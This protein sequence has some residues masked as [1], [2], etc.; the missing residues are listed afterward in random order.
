MFSRRNWF[1]QIDIDGYAV[2]YEFR[3]NTKSPYFTKCEAQV[4]YVR[5]AREQRPLEV[6]HLR[7]GRLRRS[8][9]Q[10]WFVQSRCWLHWRP[11]RI[12]LARGI[13]NQARSIHMP[14]QP[15]PCVLVFHLSNR[16]WAQITW[17]GV[18]EK[19][20]YQSQYHPNHCKGWYH[21][22]DRTATIQIENYPGTVIE[23]RS[24]LSISNGRW[25]RFRG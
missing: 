2:Q 6:N 4:A 20:R 10:R 13:E 23:R 19:T 25:I 3:I 8:D 24:Y 15:D 12:V 22:E 14:W 21:F 11:I 16:S 5:A 17:F 7:Y 9:Q 18:H 1:G